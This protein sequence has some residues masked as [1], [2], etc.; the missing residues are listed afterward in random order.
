[1]RLI[2]L[3]IVQVIGKVENERT[4]STSEIQVWGVG[5]VFSGERSDIYPTLLKL[6]KLPMSNELC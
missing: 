4:F 1:M 5:R 2:K 6:V 3:A